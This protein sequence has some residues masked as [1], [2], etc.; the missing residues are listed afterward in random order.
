VSNFT[1]FFG[2]CLFHVLK[3][4]NRM[5]SSETAQSPER[6]L[7]GVKEQVCIHTRQ[8]ERNGCRWTSNLA[9]DP[10]K[11]RSSDSSLCHEILYEPQTR[12]PSFSIQPDCVQC[13]YMSQP[14]LCHS[15]GIRS[16]ECA[17]QARDCQLP[18]IEE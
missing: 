1:S 15:D 5:M 3:M 9:E 13:L 14:T 7:D 11:A 6:T 16:T 17:H 18:K 12:N 8:R 10:K 2:A 4:T